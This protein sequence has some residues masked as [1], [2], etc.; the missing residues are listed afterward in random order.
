MSD[1]SMPIEVSSP[2][3]SQPSFTRH[4]VE[5]TGKA[6]EFFRIWIVNILLSILTLGIYSAWA[7]VRTNQYL[8]SH[9]KIAGHA[10]R[11]L[12]NPLQILKGRLMALAVF[13]VIAIA[14]YFSPIFSLVFTVVLL[15]AMPWLL[16]QSIKFKLR[17]TAYRNIRF[18]FHGTYGQT[19]K[20]MIG[21]PLLSVFTFYLLMPYAIKRLD[22]FVYNNISYGN[23]RAQVQLKAGTYYSTVFMIL[24]ISIAFAIV[25]GIA[26]VVLGMLFSAAGEA[27]AAILT[28][29]FGGLAYI[30]FICLVNALWKCT[31]RNYIFNE[32]H[33]EELATF[34][35]SM[36]TGSFAALMGTNVLAVAATLGLAYPWAVMRVQQYTAAH[37]H[38]HLSNSIEQMID[39]LS[40]GSSAFA[41]EASDL[42][43][44]DFALV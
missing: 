1:Q 25:F 39:P 37:T 33:V 19:F 22:E 13:L 16:M 23:K 28:M 5:F 10:F 14:N 34:E 3:V 2:S 41:E 9:T 4:T 6:G 38:V 21:L 12:A 36:E 27:A 8:Y 30:A 15:V 26:G 40:Q 7:K 31:I 20:Y 44:V 11:Y 43:D 24:G 35:S 32:L 18:G 17:M 29:I 42:Y